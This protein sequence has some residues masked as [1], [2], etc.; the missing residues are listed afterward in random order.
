MNPSSADASLSA[1]DPSVP[2]TAVVVNWNGR[3]HLELCIESLLGQ[4]LPGVEVVLV[5]NGST[6]G[7]VD[8]VRERFGERV[9]L[10]TESENVGY[11]RG[12]NDGIRA[13][14]GRYLFA[15]NNDTEVSPDC[16]A[17]L[18][19]SAD[20]HPNAGMFAPKILNF[21]RRDVI[22]N[23][24]HLLYPDGLSRGRG[25]L[26]EDRGQYDRE[27]EILLASGCAVLL[28]RAMLADV[29]LFDEVL[30]AYCDDTDLGLRAQ[31]AGWRCRCVPVAVVYHKYSAATTAYS[32]L[33]AFLVE[34]NRAWVAIRCLPL[35]LLVASPFFTL[36][37]FAAQA[38]GALRGQGAAGRFTTDHSP[39][40]LLAVLARAGAAALRGLPQAWHKRR[41]TQLGRRIPALASID[42]V[43]R[44]GMGVREIALKD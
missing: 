31:L 37:R 18:I 3:R 42:W 4:T 24:G 30:F 21:D 23:V 39:L 16:L 13:A 33:K 29:G 7:S 20:R 1:Y 43:R 15:L 5:D 12:L 22:D 17:A 27:E 32:P 36:L 28:R 2:V 11:A 19:E 34:R 8:F 44:H 6:D 9:R 14:H 25:R 10:V 35:P 41:E 40:A 26:E 38:W